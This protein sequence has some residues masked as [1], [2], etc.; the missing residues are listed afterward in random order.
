MSSLQVDPKLDPLHRSQVSRAG[1]KD[2]VL[3]LVWLEGFYCFISR[4]DPDVCLNLISRIFGL[5]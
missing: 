3:I 2:G 1:E 5:T 4:K